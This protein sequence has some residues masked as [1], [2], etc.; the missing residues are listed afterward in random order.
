M[1]R[2]RR[3]RISPSYLGHEGGDGVENGGRDWL[4]ARSAAAEP[5]ARR[6]AELH[7]RLQAVRFELLRAEQLAR[8]A[9]VAASHAVGV[10]DLAHEPV[11]EVQERHRA[12]VSLGIDE[13]VGETAGGRPPHR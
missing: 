13:E 7:Q 4:A 11:P 5:L 8:A 10:T 9:A 3:S 12:F 1:P 6:E 2:V